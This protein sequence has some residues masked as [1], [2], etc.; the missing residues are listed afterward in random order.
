MNRRERTARDWVRSEVD[1]SHRVVG[2]SSLNDQMV[3]GS[4]AREALAR[5]PHDV[6]GVR[7]WGRHHTPAP[8]YSPECHPPPSPQTLKQSHHPT[9]VYHSWFAEGEGSLVAG[10]GGHNER[11]QQLALLHLTLVDHLGNI[12]VDPGTGDPEQMEEGVGMHLVVADRFSTVRSVRERP[13]CSQ[14]PAAWCRTTKDALG[15]FLELA[16]LCW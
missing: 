9:A 10:V 6:L 7:C 12:V 4:D 5:V 11:R 15:M 3:G 16:A 14:R 1:P 8:P 2:C 13:R